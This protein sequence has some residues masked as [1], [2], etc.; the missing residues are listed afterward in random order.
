MIRVGTRTLA[1]VLLALAATACQTQD[2]KA[3]PSYVSSSPNIDGPAKLASEVREQGYF[4]EF[5]SRYALSYGHSYVVFGRI[6][7]NGSMINPEV[8]GLAP[9]TNDTAPYVIGHFL[10][11]PAE[12]GWSDGDLE[13]GYRSASWRIMLTEAEYNK[14][15]ADIRKLKAKA[16]FWHASLYNCNAFVA[17][18]ARSMGYQAPNIW[19][20]PQEFITKLRQM[21]GG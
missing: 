11:V 19:L 17:E 12:T 4:I 8:A 7:K 16:R 10:P 6:D 9:A 13:E 15:V 20:R 21:N 1:I 3:Q 5:R 14:V 18:I 2:K